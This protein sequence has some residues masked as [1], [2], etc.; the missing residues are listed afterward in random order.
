MKTKGSKSAGAI[1]GAGILV[2][3]LVAAPSRVDGATAEIRTVQLAAVA[4]PFLPSANSSAAIPLELNSATGILQVNNSALATTPTA[5]S[6]PPALLQI[7]GPIVLVALIVAFVIIAG[8]VLL[9]SAALYY[10]RA[11]ISYLFNSVSPATASTAMV[12]TSAVGPESRDPIA[13]VGDNLK[14]LGDGIAKSAERVP[15]A[16]AAQALTPVA[17]ADVALNRIAEGAVP[18]ATVEAINQVARNLTAAGVPKFVEQ[19]LLSSEKLGVT[20]LQAWDLVR[21]ATVGVGQKG[22]TGIQKAVSGDPD[23]PDA[24]VDP[25]DAGSDTAPSIAQLGAIRSPGTGVQQALENVGGS[26]TTSVSSQKAVGT[27]E[28]GNATVV[29]EKSGPG[30]AG[31]IVRAG[32]D[33]G[34][35][36][37]AANPTRKTPVRDAIANVRNDI[38]KVVTQVRDSGT[39]ALSGGEKKKAPRVNADHSKAAQ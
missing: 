11:A 35:P 13:S 26:L 24:H 25:Y 19:T 12:A 37:G 15:I 22:V 2:V 33:N 16:L 30:N 34:S 20:V 36:A 31:V 1:V 28:L 23:A 21:G 29:A 18:A 39:K 14:I 7:V 5:I 4:L 9:P 38:H 8:P 3:G 32:R 27:R 10:A 17:V 6:I